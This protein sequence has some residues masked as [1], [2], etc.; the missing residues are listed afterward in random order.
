MEGRAK[1]GR[2]RPKVCHCSPDG[3]APAIDSSRPAIHNLAMV[4]PLWRMADYN[5]WANAQIIEACRG[6]SSEQL[7]A[8]VEGTAGSIRE[9][10]VHVVDGQRVFLGRL[11]GVAREPGSEPWPG[12]PGFGVLAAEAERTSRL[13]TGVAE[14]MTEEAEVVLPYEGKGYRFPRSFF[15]L[16]A[17]EHGIE[18]RTHIGLPMAQLGLPHPDLDGWA[19]ATASGLG[20]EEPIA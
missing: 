3:R 18:H 10:L 13:L 2:Q 20:E 16:H 5:R 12:W 7:D 11:E 14:R 4:N 6:L 1:A 9:M 19:Y 8:R 17:L 15:L